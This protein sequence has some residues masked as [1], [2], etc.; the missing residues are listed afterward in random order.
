[1]FWHR[2]E[3]PIRLSQSFKTWKFCKHA[4][5]GIEEKLRS[6]G[7]LNSGT[8]SRHDYE[9][10]KFQKTENMDLVF[11]FFGEYELLSLLVLFQLLRYLYSHIPFNH[12]QL[13]QVYTV[14]TCCFLIGGYFLMSYLMLP[15]CSS[16]LPYTLR[17]WVGSGTR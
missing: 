1:M 6:L 13:Q 8:Q 17:W 3:A 15:P 7:N 11:Y 9:K 10:S 2:R 16:Q 12:M 5:F 14:L 4:C